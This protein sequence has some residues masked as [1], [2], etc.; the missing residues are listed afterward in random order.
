ML[1]IGIICYPTVGGSGVVATELGHQLALLGHEVHFISY[2]APFRLQLENENIFFHKVEIF[3]YDLFQYPDYALPLAVKM[4]DVAETRHLDIFHVH[5]AIPH[6]TS[7]FLAREMIGEGAPA[8]IT[9][10]HGTDITLV[11]RERSY[12]E[13]VKLSIEKSDV[14]TTVSESLATQTKEIL[15]IEHPIHTIPNFFEP[16]KSVKDIRDHYVQGDE[17][18]LV[19]ASN[20]RSVKRPQDLLPIFRKVREK[21]PCKL[22][23][24]G[25][26]E[27]MER[28]EGVILAGEHLDIDAFVAAADLFL[29]PSEQESFGLVALESMAYGT[30]VVASAAGGLPELIEH[31]VSGMLS[32]V[33]DVELMAQNCL[34]L[35]QNQEMMSII[36]QGAITKAEHYK[37]ERVIP[38]YEGAYSQVLLNSRYCSRSRT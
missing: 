28:E 35:L 22:L 25:P 16:K 10:L 17:K 11:G 38:L 30:P 27:G 3:T 1:K 5:Y 14:V 24:V 36:S 2:E 20:F 33:G 6:A 21:M 32:P 13:V 26:A 18:L 9:T 29:L 8:I 34:H 31:G 19:H 15:G 4:A 37:A 7:A 12:L 23:L